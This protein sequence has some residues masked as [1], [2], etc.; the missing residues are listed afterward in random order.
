MIAFREFTRQQVPT[1]LSAF[2]RSE[3]PPELRTSQVQVEEFTLA[4]FR[5]V[6]EMV[7]EQWS[8]R[9]AT[10]QES[11]IDSGYGSRSRDISTHSSPPQI[12]IS[13]QAPV[14]SIEDGNEPPVSSGV[15]WETEPS[16]NPDFAQEFSIDSVVSNVLGNLPDD[17]SGFDFFTD[18]E[19]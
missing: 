7:I 5:G 13:H 6:F 1:L 16:T 2:A 8:E 3:I 19:L 9:E 17:L 14:Q 4:A 12:Q 18:L 11:P 10:Q 15:N